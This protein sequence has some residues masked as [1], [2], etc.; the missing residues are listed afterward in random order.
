VQSRR[1]QLQ[2][3]KFLTRR[4]LAALVV[5]EPD[6]PEAPMRRLSLTTITGIMAA[7]LVVAGFAVFGLVRPGTNVKL[8]TGTIYIERETGAQFVL[9]GDGQL[10]P[11]LNYTSAVLAITAGGNNQGKVAVKTVAA[12]TLAHKEHGYAVG[13]DDIPPSLPRSTSRL[14]KAPVTVCSKATALAADNNI[15]KVT[16]T[17]GGQ[18]G[19]TPLRSDEAVLVS[20]PGGQQNYMLWNGR[21]LQIG[22]S[23]QNSRA[24]TTALNLGNSQAIT[25]GTGLLNA[26]PQGTS[27][28]TPKIPDAGSPGPPIGN[29]RA[30][31]GQLIQITDNHSFVVVLNDGIA[32]VTQVMA[33]LLE[34]LPLR[35]GKPIS[36]IQAS[37]ATVLGLNGQSTSATDVLKQFANLP[38]QA[39][40]VPDTPG[41]AGGV[42]AVYHEDSSATLAVPPGAAPTNGAAVSASQASLRGEADEVDVPAEKASLITADQHSKTV[43]VIAAPGKK[44]AASPSALGGLGYGSVSPLKVPEQL[45]QMLPNGPALDTAAV[46]RS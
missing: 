32:P 25:V 11:A 13:I 38:S 5:G 34:T 22:T 45:L 29:V 12:S 27:L 40:H 30:L 2:A 46:R 39:P 4:A 31:V 44:F 33:G 41:Q 26:L 19:A 42:C 23:A 3:Y 35:N 16:V 1:D 37:Q 15:A 10:H 24:I 8:S 21:R 18:A 43:F 7:V 14:V 20:A 28:V 6:V 17:I 9:L 36:P